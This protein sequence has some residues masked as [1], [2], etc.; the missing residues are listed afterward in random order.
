[1]CSATEDAV[2]NDHVTKTGK[3]RDKDQLNYPSC[4]CLA[5]HKAGWAAQ[6]KATYTK[7]KRANH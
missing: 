6:K 1:M 3:L 4:V 2:P 7:E 5:T